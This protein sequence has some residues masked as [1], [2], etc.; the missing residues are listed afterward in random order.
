MTL[1]NVSS[2]LT[3]GNECFLTH[4][5]VGPH[6]VRRGQTVYVND[7][8][9]ILNPMGESVTDF[10]DILGGRPRDVQLLFFVNSIDPVSWPQAVGIPKPPTEL[11]VISFTASF[12]GDVT[13][14]PLSKEEP[15]FG[16][17]HGTR[18]VR[19]LGKEKGCA[20]YDLETFPEGAAVI[21]LRGDCTF[22]EKLAFAA[23]AGASGIIVV[24]DG[25][26]AINPSADKVDV[27]AAGDVIKHVP[28]VLVPKT[29]G[30]DILRM[31]VAAEM[32]DVDVMV[33]V[34]PEGHGKLP[35]QQT[36]QT[37]KG[38]RRPKEPAGDGRVLYLNGHPLL[39]TRV[40]V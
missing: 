25:D 18:V 9:L 40:L 10:E 21:L 38:S 27:E 2:S 7:S 20:P 11:S 15:S 28:L 31:V 16:Y 5:T 34:E 12:G 6:A 23:S 22:I 13:K 3:W 39:N 8:N 33:V 24:S 14:T 32:H 1:S 17:G 37:Q 19:I 35:T 29:S 30:L 4:V 26:I 36:Q